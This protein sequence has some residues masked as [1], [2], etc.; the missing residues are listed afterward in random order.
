MDRFR[1]FIE[2]QETADIGPGLWLSVVLSIIL[3]RDFLEHILSF[4]MI[5]SVNAFHFLHFPVFFLS[6]L[7][8]VCLLLHFF[9]GSRIERV[10]RAALI[11]FPLIVLPVLIDGI[12]YLVSGKEVSYLYLTGNLRYNFLNMLN[13]W[14]DTPDIPAGI[15]VEAACV[16]IAHAYRENHASAR[17]LTDG[18]GGPMMRREALA[19]R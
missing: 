16:F 18:S 19:G 9:S 6:I 17:S 4:R 10:C 2:K 3:V 13:P 8:A 7:L 12:R 1:T 11:F 5:D 14:C 15:R